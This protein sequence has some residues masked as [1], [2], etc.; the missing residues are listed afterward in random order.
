MRRIV[1]G[2]CPVFVVFL[3][4]LISLAPALPLLAQEQEEG[5]DDLFEEQVLEDDAGEQA[6]GEEDGEEAELFEEGV[7]EGQEAPAEEASPEEASPE[8]V[9]LV[10]ERLEWGG[11]FELLF[12]TRVSWDGYPDSWDM[13]FNEGDPF[14][15]TQ[16]AADLFFDARPE[17]DFRVFGKVKAAYEY[18]FDSESYDWD[19]GIFELFADFQYKDL[20]FFRAGKQTVQW[21]VGYFFSPADVLSLVSIDPEDP[22]A[23][24]E[25]PIALKTH[26]PFAAHNAYLYLVA[27]DITKPSEI[28]VAPKLELVT[29]DYELGIGGFYQADLAPKGMLTLT[30]PLW[31][32]QLFSEAV[33]QSGSDFDPGNDDLLFSG[34][35]GFA[36][37]N[38]DWDLTVVAQ[39]LFAGEGV[40]GHHH[41]A[42]GVNWFEFLDSP[43]T[44][45]VIYQANFSDGS[46][47]II[48][49][50]TWGPIDYLSL[51]TGLRI[52]YGETEYVH[53]PGRPAYTFS[54][55]IGGL[56]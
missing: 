19:I 10:S 24:R 18:Q 37:V 51:S 41:L 39:Y 45:L 20:L 35:A 26:L 34:T 6:P 56:F 36:Y 32:L 17:R 44:L 52:G 50:I 23:E 48:P 47:L 5:F 46:G 9:F 53:G 16:L 43:F 55:S 25:G 14:L 2:K 4:F 13:L 42:A 11:S 7:L 28:A 22:E 3:V 31:E 21:G 38:P 29:G 33:L 8:E 30:G 27:N 12:D 1:P 40:M 15:N 54:V 49:S